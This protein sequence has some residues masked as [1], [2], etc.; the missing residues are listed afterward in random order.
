MK[1]KTFTILLGIALLFPIFVSAHSADELL[2]GAKMTEVETNLNLGNEDPRTMTAAIINVAL[3]FIG[4]ICILI[5]IFGVVKGAGPDGFEGSRKF[6]V[7][8]VIGL[9]ITLM[10][11]GLA[12]FAMSSL[13]TATG[14][15]G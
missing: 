3:G 12:Q 10:A 2:W 13:F 5:I 8:G 4:I 1:K 15:G 14:A 7:A 6:I 9:I 11:F